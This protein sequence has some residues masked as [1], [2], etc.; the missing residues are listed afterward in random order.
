MGKSKCPY[1][2]SEISS[3]YDLVKPEIFVLPNRISKDAAAKMFKTHKP[4]R[5]GCIA[6]CSGSVVEYHARVPRGETCTSATVSTTS[7]AWTGLGSNPGV[8]DE[9]PTVMVGQ[10]SSV[11]ETNCNVI[12]VVIVVA[13]DFGPYQL[14]QSLLHMLT[15]LTA[16][17]HMLTLVTVAAVPD[18]R[19]DI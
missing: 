19:L 16:G 17:V 9:M 10:L 4:E 12:I 2:L 5:M 1:E 15:A 7:P 11:T 8:R 13:G 6:C 3:F 18:H 14:R